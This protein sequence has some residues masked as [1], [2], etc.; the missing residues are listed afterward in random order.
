TYYKEFLQQ[1]LSEYPNYFLS[2]KTM[3]SRIVNKLIERNE[4]I[5]CEEIEQALK[6]TNR[7]D[8]YTFFKAYS[9]TFLSVNEEKFIEY[10]VLQ[11]NS[12]VHNAGRPDTKTRKKLAAMRPP[13]DE[14]LIST[15]AKKLRTKFQRILLK[16]HDRIISILTQG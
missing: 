12:Y 11:R 8:Y 16:S 13:F 7:F 6:L 2:R 14:C 4:S 10:I 1:L 5:T 9:V 3:Y 15:E